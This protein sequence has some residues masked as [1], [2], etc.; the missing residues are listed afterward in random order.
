MTDSSEIL[1]TLF[2]DETFPIEWDSE[3]KRSGK[4]PQLCEEFSSVRPTYFIRAA[5]PQLLMDEVE[6]LL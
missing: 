3:E 4:M 1:G 6:K 5:N 2:G